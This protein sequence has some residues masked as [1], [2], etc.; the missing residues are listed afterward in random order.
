MTVLSF[1]AG[2]LYLQRQRL[3]FI[4][5]QGLLVVVASLVAEHRL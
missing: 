5:T 1:V 4:V 3:R 2:F